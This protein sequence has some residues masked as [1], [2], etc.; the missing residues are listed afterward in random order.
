MSEKK[1]YIPLIIISLFV[2]IVILVGGLTNYKDETLTC[3]R[4][5]NICKI[6]KTNLFNMT[7]EKNLIKIS[8]I[9]DITYYTQKVKGN[10]YGKG[11]REYFLAFNT[12]N[13]EQIKIFSKSY[14]DKK[15]LSDAIHNLKSKLFTKGNNETFDFKRDN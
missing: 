5:A 15:E 6:N 1:N 14:Y 11:Y 4:T 2:I 7:C 8:E 3:N 12:K 13:N 9:N 10:R